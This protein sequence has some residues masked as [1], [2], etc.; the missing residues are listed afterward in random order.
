MCCITSCDRPVEQ[1]Y[2][3]CTMPDHRALEKRGIEEHSAMFQ[4]RKR[5]E[6]RRTTLIDDSMSPNQQEVDPLTALAND[7][8]VEMEGSTSCAGK[9]ETGNVRLRA[10]F[11][12][13][14]THSEQLCVATCGVVLRRATFYGSEAVNGVR[15]STSLFFLLCLTALAVPALTSFLLRGRPCTPSFPFSFLLPLFFPPPSVAIC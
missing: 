2:Q 6:R 9:S 11:G 8:A 7:D 3:T 10:R 1:G 5:L 13:S 4:L 15:V 14:R 12:R